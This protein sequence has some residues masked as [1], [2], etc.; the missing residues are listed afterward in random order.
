MKNWK[1]QD[2]KITGTACLALL[3]PLTLSW[4]NGFKPRGAHLDKMEEKNCGMLPNVAG[5][6]DMFMLSHLPAPC[7]MPESQSTIVHAA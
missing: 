7:L 6:K 3:K 4:R 1:K 2:V 5:S